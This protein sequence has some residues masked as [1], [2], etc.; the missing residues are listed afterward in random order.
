MITGWGSHHLDIAHWA[1]GWEATGPKTI[2]GKGAFHT[3]GLWD[4]HGEYDVTLTYADGT[5]MR[6]WDKFP[7]GVRFIGEKGWIFCGRGSVKTLSDDPGAGGKHGRWRPLEASAKGLIEGEVEKPL[8]RNPQ[9]H[10]RVWLESIRTRQPT[11]TTPEAAHRTTTAC[12][13]AY[14][15]MNLKRPLAWDPAAERFVK[16]DAANATLSR[17]ER[18]PY[19]VRHALKRAGFEVTF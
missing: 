13:L 15:A 14:T 5:A 9:N 1:M 10:H 17:P 16:D 19:G 18:A 6:V 3:G 8:P 11:N 12:I 7:N 2:E 4:V